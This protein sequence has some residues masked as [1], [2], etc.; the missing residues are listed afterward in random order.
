MVGNAVKANPALW[1]RVLAMR[2]RKFEPDN[3]ARSNQWAAR[4]YKQLGGRYRSGGPSKGQ[5]S[6][7]RWEREKW[8]GRK[9]KPCGKKGNAKGEKKGVCRPTRRVSAQTPKTRA[10][11]GPKK[12]AAAQR[13]KGAG[14]RARF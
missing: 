7:K 8:E 9:G 11:V 10:Q 6:L 12:M 2:N 5:T 13:R 14:K 1:K 4:K 3:S